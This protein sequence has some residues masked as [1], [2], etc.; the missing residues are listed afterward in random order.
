MLT[1]AQHRHASAS[2]PVTAVRIDVSSAVVRL[3]LRYVSEERGW[4]R[5]CCHDDLCRCL[6]IADQCHPCSAVDVLVT[7]DLPSNCQEALDAVLA[8]TARA[9][10][11]WDEPMS[12]G[13]TVDALAQRSSVIPERVIHLALQAPRLNERQR[14]TLRLIAAGRSNSE[15]SS[16]LHQSSST[17]KRDIGELL[18]IFDT[19]NRAGL[20]TAAARLGFL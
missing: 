8:G 15:I 16:A 20:T 17:T 2:V 19:A 18:V 4:Q 10:V 14:Q 7:R 3:A 11:L 9:V 6:A 1:V 12:L 5:C 13:P